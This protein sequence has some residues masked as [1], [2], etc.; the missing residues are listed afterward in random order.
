MLTSRRS[1]AFSGLHFQDGHCLSGRAFAAWHCQQAEIEAATVCLDDR[2]VKCR[3][4]QDPRTLLLPDLP[5]EDDV[6]WLLRQA[7]PTFVPA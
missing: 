4:R 6:F 2:F 5:V 7:L 1:T 3:H